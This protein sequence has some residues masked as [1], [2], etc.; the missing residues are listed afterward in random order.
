[1]ESLRAARAVRGAEGEDRSH[2]R[3]DESPRGGPRGGARR[4]RRRAKIRRDSRNT[5]PTPPRTRTP[6]PGASR[7]APRS[8]SASPA[9]ARGISRG[10]RAADGIARRRG[11]N[12]HA[13]LVAARRETMRNVVDAAAARREEGSEGG[14][15]RQESR[16]RGGTRRGEGRRRRRRRGI[17]RPAKR[18]ARFAATTPSKTAR[19][20]RD[21][22]SRS[23]SPGADAASAPVVE[24]LLR[25][26]MED[27]ISASLE[28]G[29]CYDDEDGSVIV[30]AAAIVQRVVAKYEDRRDERDEDEDAVDADASNAAET[31]TETPRPRASRR[32]NERRPCLCSTRTPRVPRR[33]PRSLVATRSR[34]RRRE[35]DFARSSLPRGPRRRTK[36]RGRANARCSRADCAR[37]EKRRRRRK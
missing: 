30:G 26:A 15:G 1:M 5:S 6:R 21:L 4:R 18:S 19:R 20:R 11:W 16:L 32:T 25:D 23:A 31:G 10:R 7:P 35:D 37:R 17:P 36:T 9:A 28:L 33:V 14:G 24:G 34:R 3:G 27:E 12:G 13:E 2:R 29:Y 22:T 8:R